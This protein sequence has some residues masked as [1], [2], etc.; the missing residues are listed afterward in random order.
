ML[1]E[2]P[3]AKTAIVLLEAEPASIL[4]R[5]ISWK[6]VALP[7]ELIV[8][9]STEANLLGVWP[10]AKTPLSGVAVRF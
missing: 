9:K 6:S 2:S 10:I 1:P 7:S 3:P 4:A 5:V 8:T